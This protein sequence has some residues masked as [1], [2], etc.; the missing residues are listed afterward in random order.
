MN[1]QTTQLGPSGPSTRGAEARS[2]FGNGGNAERLNCPMSDA[3]VGALHEA[4]Y[5][6]LS[7][8][9]V[10]AETGTPTTFIGSLALSVR[11]A[12]VTK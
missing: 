3:N 11:S 4:G 9:A 2:Y 6:T 1:L 8:P 12:S 10:C 7:R 5:F